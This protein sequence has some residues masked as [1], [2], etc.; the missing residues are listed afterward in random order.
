[1][2]DTLQGV[3]WSLQRSCPFRHGDGWEYPKQTGGQ[4][5]DFETL[6]RAMSHGRVV[7]DVC[8]T[9]CSHVSPFKTSQGET[10]S[11]SSVEIPLTGFSVSNRFGKQGGVPAILETC[12][13]CEA[14]ALRKGD[15]R[16]AGCHGYLPVWPLSKELEDLLQ[17]SLAELGVADSFFALFQKTTPIWY[18]LWIESP[19]R[20]RHARV[21]RPVLERTFAAANEERTGMGHFLQALAVCDAFDMPLH[22]R[23][24]PLGH[25]DSSRY[26]VAA[27]CPRCKAPTPAKRWQKDPSREEPICAVCGNSSIPIGAQSHEARDWDRDADSLEKMFGIEEYGRFVRRYAESQG[28]TPEQADVA[29]HEELRLR[30]VREQI[31]AENREKAERLLAE[32]RE[33]RPC[34]QCGKSL[35]TKLA[36]QCFECGADW[37]E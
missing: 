35:R 5:A 20:R 29:W 36:K 34:P 33:P 28:Y 3:G 18:G 2:A 4:L 21:L 19:L 27:H 10:D 9:S 22:M 31:A 6:A 26:T 1:M 17:R 11:E 30:E 32:R 37:H 8:V 24:S 25:V 14:N 15:I 16:L 7:D 13:A 23:L 12:G